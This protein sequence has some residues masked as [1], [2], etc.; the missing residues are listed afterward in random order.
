[1]KNVLKISIVLLALIMTFSSCKKEEMSIQNPE[2]TLTPE[3]DNTYKLN[4][5]QDQLSISGKIAPENVENDEV[6][7]KVTSETDPTGF[8][9]TVSTTDRNYTE[10]K[11]K[12]LYKSFSTNVFA[13]NHTDAELRR[14]K[15]AETNGKIT[16]TIGDDIISG[17]SSVED[18]EV[19]TTTYWPSDNSIYLQL[20]GYS[21]D[22]SEDIQL[23]AW[24]GF[25]DLHIP[26]D[27]ELNTNNN[28]TGF[29]LYEA[30]IEYYVDSWSNYEQQTLGVKATGD[31]VFILYDDKTYF[32]I[33]GENTHAPLEEY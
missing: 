9:F 14:I 10:D 2:L 16:I 13:A 5:Y 30:D 24:T 4:Y 22:G 25:D 23:E 7:V 26:I 12:Y 20:Y 31:T 11:T 6:T 3:N 18:G 15:V 28:S 1:M 27:M 32:S 19:L 8:E 21:F 33:V 17:S 29:G